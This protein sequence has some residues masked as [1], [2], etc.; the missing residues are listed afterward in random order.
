MK[1]DKE[2]YNQDLKER[3]KQ[4]SLDVIY[5]FKSLSKETVSQ[6]VGKQLLRSA[7][8]VGA[9]ELT[10]IFNSIKHKYRN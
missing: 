4:F 1:L 3:T 8:S 9:N 7:T 5:L 10:A 6:V 2:N